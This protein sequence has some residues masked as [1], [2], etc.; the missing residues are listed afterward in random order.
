MRGALFNAVF[1]VIVSVDE[2]STTCVWNLQVRNPVTEIDDSSKGTQLQCLLCWHDRSGGVSL[3]QMRAAYSKA[4]CSANPAG[5]AQHSRLHL[6]ANHHGCCRGEMLLAN[7]LGTYVSAACQ[8]HTVYS[9]ANRPSNRRPVRTADNG[10]LAVCRMGH[11]RAAS[12]PARRSRQQHSRTTQR[13][14]AALA[15]PARTA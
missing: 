9:R 12:M 14:T 11:G 6:L 5:G 4:S 2:A 8:P 15:A 13:T 10:A 7:V 3:R 1:S